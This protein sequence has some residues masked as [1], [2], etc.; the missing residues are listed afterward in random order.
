MTDIT[1]VRRLEL[2]SANTQTHICFI[3]SQEELASVLEE[4]GRLRDV[5][6]EQGVQLYHLDANMGARLTEIEYLK[7]DLRS[8]MDIAKAECNEVET[9]RNAAHNACFHWFEC[10]HGE[11]G[12]FEGAMNLLKTASAYDLDD[13]DQ[14]PS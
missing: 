7:H 2:I 13:H 8:Y 11:C 6:R 4:I 12:T 3:I 14:E 5:V 1:E 9:I 10:E